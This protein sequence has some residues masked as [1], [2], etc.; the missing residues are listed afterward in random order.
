M[1]RLPIRFGQKNYFFAPRSSETVNFLRPLAL[2]A[3]ITFLPPTL[4]ILLLK[5]CLLVLFL[6]DG[7]NVLFIAV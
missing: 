5:P 4:S 6:L 2:R 1:L 3:L 7:W